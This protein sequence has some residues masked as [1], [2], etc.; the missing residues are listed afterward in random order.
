MEDV[1]DM[2][3]NFL[4][5]DSIEG[6]T[7]P[8][9]IIKVSHKIDF[10]KKRIPFGACTMTCI[11]AK[12]NMKQRCVPE[13]SLRPSNNAGGNYFMYLYAGKILHSYIWEELPITDDVIEQFAIQKVVYIENTQ[14]DKTPSFADQ[15]TE[16]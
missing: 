2:L 1:I 6:K 9:I 12:N 16:V 4:A 5:K 7:P 8:A 11:G 10:R 3:N 14:E 13:I 15:F